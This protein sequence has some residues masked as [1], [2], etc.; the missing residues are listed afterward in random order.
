VAAGDNV[1]SALTWLNDLAQWIGRWVPRLALIHPTHR[2]VRFGRG[3]VALSVG[4]GLVLYWPLI[5]DLIQVPV[6]TISY[7]TCAQTLFLN[8]G[9]DAIVPHIAVVGNAVQ[10]R[11]VDP[12][13]A[14]VNALNYHAIVDNRVQAAV[15]RHWRGSL[16]DREWC[17]AARAEAAAELKEFGIDLQHLDVTNIGRG[18]ALKNISDWSYSDTTDGKRPS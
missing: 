12:I 2:G 9:A 17:A 11:V 3:G 8:T 1:T 16:T 5:H 7:Q 18:C 14:A 6:T 4:P 13:K 15:S 10:F